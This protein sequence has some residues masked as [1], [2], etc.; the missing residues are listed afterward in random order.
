MRLGQRQPDGCTLR[1]HLQAAVVATGKPNPVLALALPVCVT[2]LWQAFC[3]MARPVGMAAGA[4]PAVEIEAWQR[5]SGV[6][7]SPWEVDT[8]RAMD[9]AAMSA[10]SEKTP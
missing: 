6:T 8:L 9:R 7:L 10:M 4:I 5:L 3:E 1:E 2:G